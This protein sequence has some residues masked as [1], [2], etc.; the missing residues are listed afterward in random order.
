MKEAEAHRK[1]VLNKWGQ[2]KQ[3]LSRDPLVRKHWE[4]LQ[5]QYHS[6]HPALFAFKEKVGECRMGKFDTAFL[7][8]GELG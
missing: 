5:A 2:Q 4:D 6:R 1:N 7:H 3:Y 8:R